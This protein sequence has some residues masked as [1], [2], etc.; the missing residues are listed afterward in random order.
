MDPH[1]EAAGWS[2]VTGAKATRDPPET[3]SHSP[4]ACQRSGWA[5]WCKSPTP[6]WST[7]PTL[8]GASARAIAVGLP[9]KMGGISYAFDAAAGCRLLYCLE[10]RLPRHGEKPGQATGAGMPGCSGRK[11]I[12]RPAH[13]PLR[14]GKPYDPAEKPELEFKGYRPGGGSARVSSIRWMVRTC[15]PFLQAMRNEPAVKHSR[16]HFSLPAIHR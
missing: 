13:F 14:I 16:M 6:R 11:S 10:W 4:L 2:Q 5:R 3:A 8:P 9:A 15:S 7:G 12:R 1:A